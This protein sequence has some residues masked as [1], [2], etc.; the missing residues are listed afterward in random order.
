MSSHCR[1]LFSTKTIWVT[2][3]YGNINLK[4]NMPSGYKNTAEF[5]LYGTF[6]QNVRKSKIR[7]IIT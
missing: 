1:L 4:I 7:S 2:N 3:T 5:K 6:T